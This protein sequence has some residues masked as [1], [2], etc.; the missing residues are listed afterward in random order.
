MILPP[1]SAADAPSREFLSRLV[2]LRGYAPVLVSS[3]NAVALATLAAEG[4]TGITLSLGA[5]GCTLG[6][7]HR[8]RELTR[9]AEPRGGDWIDARL[10]ASERRYIHD[11]AG[12]RYLDTEA[13][14]R[15]REALAESLT[16]PTEDFAARVAEY[17]RELL[18]ST[19]KE[20]GRRIKDERLGPFASPLPVVCSGGATRA[21]GFI[22]L[23]TATLAAADLPLMVGPVRL[24]PADEYLAARG[25]LI[26]AE[27]EAT[28]AAAA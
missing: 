6:L 5:G 25:A 23:M 28:C 20:L 13:V 14:R 19:A 16:R 2:M 9:V 7:A 24:A 11:S 10:A 21:A 17:Y 4:F 15:Q 3:S 1:S 8:G 12:E 26:H 18:L 22:G 27:L